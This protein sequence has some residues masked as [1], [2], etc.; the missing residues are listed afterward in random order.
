MFVVQMFV[1]PCMQGKRTNNF[2]F[3]IQMFVV[4]CMQGNKDTSAIRKKKQ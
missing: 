2:Y 1:V 3:F 4:P